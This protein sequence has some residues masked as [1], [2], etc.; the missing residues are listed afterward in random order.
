MIIGA[1]STIIGFRFTLTTLMILILSIL[2]S[3]SS[4]IPRKL[5]RFSLKSIAVVVIVV[6]ISFSV[7]VVL[8]GNQFMMNTPKG[9]LAEKV[10]QKLFVDRASVWKG[11]VNLISQPPY[12]IVPAA[13]PFLLDRGFIEWDIG[14]H[15]VVLESFRQLGL[16]IGALPVLIMLYVIIVVFRILQSYHNISYMRMYAAG[17]LGIAIVYGITGHALVGDKVGFLFWAI[18]GILVGLS[19]KENSF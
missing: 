3:I 14:A 11:A 7:M 17:F 18:G 5:M 9:S 1:A 19:D 2:L 16:L 4:I 10:S 6:F 13:R 8:S 12:F 15:N